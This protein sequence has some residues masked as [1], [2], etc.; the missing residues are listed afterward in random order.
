[1]RSVVQRQGELLKFAAYLV[2][3]LHGIEGTLEAHAPRAYAALQNSWFAGAFTK[4]EDAL[5]KMR[6]TY[7]NWSSEQVYD[8]LKEAVWDALYVAGCA[9]SR[10]DNG[11]VSVNVRQ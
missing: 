10:M 2:G 1:M 11:Q 8:P 3:H 5:K 9:L 4:L 7:P 6:E